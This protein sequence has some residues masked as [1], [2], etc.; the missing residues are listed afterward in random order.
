[1]NRCSSATI[2]ILCA[3]HG[4]ASR[5]TIAAA[6]RLEVRQLTTGP[7]HHFFGY[8]G[9]VQNI[10]WNKSGRYIVALR[11]PVRDHLPEANE[12]AEIVLLDTQNGFAA[13][14]VDRSRA[15]NPQQGTMLYWNPEAQETQF[16]FNDRDPTTNKVF[17]VLFDISPGPAGERIREFR[18]ED[19][20]I[21][22]GGVAQRGGKFLAINY[23]RMGRLRRVTGYAGAFDFT[24]DVLHPADD[25]VFQVDVASG[26]KKL[27]VSFQQLAAKLRE[28]QPAI[29]QQA[30]FINHTLWSRDDSRIYFYVR[31]GWDLGGTQ[32]NVPVVM[33]ADGTNLRPLKD[34]IGGHPEWLDGQR[35]IGTLNNEQI[36]YDCEAM[37][38][39]GTL[40]DKKIFPKPGDDIAL[41]PDAQWFVNG[42][43]LGSENFYAFLRLKDGAS[44]K[45][46]SFD[47]RGWT[48]GDLRVDPSPNWNRQNNQIL[49]SA[50]ADDPDH[51]RQL[52]L[53]TLHA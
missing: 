39:V 7:L 1:M 20:P 10:P 19:T 32:V 50:L 21:G 48:Q 46:S 6:P 28:I 15:W 43:R 17:C 11:T 16:F 27:L 30:L 47:V 53:I 18:F 38:V 44:V 25:G 2:L 52:F 31:G 4:S 24:G 3:L 49:V 36:I 45:S 13:R 42:Y 8:I 23:G 12:P 9:H 37:K 40:G 14:V 5:S 41:S 26:D 29:D 34:F 22:N 51:T 33:N 35:L